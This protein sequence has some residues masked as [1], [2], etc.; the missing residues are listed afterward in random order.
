MPV[1]FI[2]RQKS[3]PD[4]VL[5][6]CRTPEPSPTFAGIAESSG[7]KY[8]AQTLRNDLD[9]VIVQNKIGNLFYFYIV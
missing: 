7:S 5:M 9:K 4:M 1:Y 8:N 2:C 3:L 6:H